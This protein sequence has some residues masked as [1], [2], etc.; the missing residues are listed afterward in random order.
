MFKFSENTLR[1]APGEEKTTKTTSSPF[2]GFSF[3]RAQPTRDVG[4]R[5]VIISRAAKNALSTT[6]LLPL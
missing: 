6:L 4:A 2:P 1:R 3:R 5:A